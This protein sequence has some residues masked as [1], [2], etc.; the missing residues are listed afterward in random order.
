MSLW[1]Q[2]SKDLM[3]LLSRP[4]YIKAIIELW[5]TEVANIPDNKGVITRSIP[6][7][8]NVKEFLEYFDSCRGYRWRLLDLLQN[9]NVTSDVITQD[10]LD[11]LLRAECCSMTIEC[12]IRK[13]L[14]PLKV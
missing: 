14:P 1:S 13:Y 10:V 5:N 9:H 6:N 7:Y 4:G 12:P 8:S 11:K 2:Y 3:N